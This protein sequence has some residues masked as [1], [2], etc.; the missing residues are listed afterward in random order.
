MELFNTH[1]TEK[2][3]SQPAT[4]LFGS[5]TRSPAEQTVEDMLRKSTFTI[6]QGAYVYAKARSRPEKGKHF[7][8]SEDDSEITVVTKEENLRFVDVIEKNKET[9]ALFALNPSK[10]FYSVGFLGAIA[11]AIAK[12]KMDILLL[13]AYSRDYVLV[14]VQ[15]LDAAKNA[16]LKIGLKEVPL[17]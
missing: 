10:S 12:Q 13:S 2:K 1:K 7:M 6:H 4:N 16:L 3:E 5:L 15:D 17:H 14:R 11:H 8:I 9:Y